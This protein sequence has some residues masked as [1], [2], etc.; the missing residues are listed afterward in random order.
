MRK[1]ETLANHGR[2][3]LVAMGSGLLAGYLVG[4][5]M[6]GSYTHAIWPVLA[7][8]VLGMANA[9]AATRRHVLVAF[10]GGSVAVAA[11]VTEVVL[12]QFLRGRWPINDAVTIAQYGTA[13]QAAMRA[14]VILGVLIGIPCLI[15]AAVI[16][17]AKH[18]DAYIDNPQQAAARGPGTAGAAPGQ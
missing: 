7:G 17:F 14:A 8:F 10:C 16:A 11:A 13:T 6:M 2:V 5:G 3:F 12:V 1:R 18:R 15:A 9:L 4:M